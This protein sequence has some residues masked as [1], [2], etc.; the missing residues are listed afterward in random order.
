MLE[1]WEEARKLLES[2]AVVDLEKRDLRKKIA[3]CS[4][5]KIVCEVRVPQRF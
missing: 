1:E 5:A 2:S 4:F 3:F